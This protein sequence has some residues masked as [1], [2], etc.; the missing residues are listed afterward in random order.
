MRKLV[1]AFILLLALLPNAFSQDDEIYHSTYIILESEVRSS[2]EIEREPG[3]SIEY[4]NSEVYF[5]P[6]DDK[7]QNVLEIRPE[8]DATPYQDKFVF[9]WGSPGEN[10]LQYKI[11]S[12]VQVENLFERVF[13]KIDFPIKGG[14][15][16]DVAEFTN[17][18]EKIDSG[19]RDIISLANQL[20]EGEDD[21]FIVIHKLANWVKDNI[22][23]NLDTVTE[24]ATQKA[25][26]VLENRYGVCDE[27]TALFMAMARSLGI[28]ARFVSGIS[29]TNDP[30]FKEKWGP[31]GWAEVYL[32]GYGWVPFDVTY[33]E[34]GW[35]D[36][37]HIK[38]SDD[39]DPD[40]PSGKIEWKG[41]NFDVNAGRFEFSVDIVETG[42]RILDTVGITARVHKKKTGFGSYNLVEANIKN[43]RDY[44]VTT[45]I[46][47]GSPKEVEVIGKQNRQIILKPGESKKEFW[48]L[49]VSPSLSRNYVYT[50]PVVAYNQRNT[51]YST[52][53]TAQHDETVY[54][55]NEI[56]TLLGLLEEE[57]EKAYSKELDIECE[58]EKPEFYVYEQNKLSCMLENRGN[59]ALNGLNVC[60]GGSCKEVDITIA[61]RE[62]AIFDIK[63]AEPG[64]RDLIVT[65]K[66][67]DVSKTAYVPAVILDEPSAAIENIEFPAEARYDE[68]GSI[69]F[70]LI[71]ESYSDLYSAKV[72]VISKRIRHK[73]D[74]DAIN[75]T[76]NFILD[77]VA[78]DLAEG[79]NEITVLV[80][81]ED[82][83]G[84]QYSAEEKFKIK[85]TGLNLMQSL[86][87]RVKGAGF[88]FINLFS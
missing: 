40:R 12:T 56:S 14:V 23:Y 29:F 78:K 75:T 37:S 8:P 46:S 5:F 80:E 35:I 79:D 66:N 42:G 77:F 70:T 57:E 36:P 6:K 51:T 48:I 60:F 25:S 7:R 9:N 22:E 34:L 33:G 55:E 76:R 20:A 44:Y 84:K 21:L 4:I 81:F 32:P 85:L 28:P 71:K 2:L 64:E 41:R 83:N 15:P 13:N 11:S 58:A 3:A 52:E 73:W 87:V 38:L 61:Q 18:T 74:I 10:L 69:K 30:Q 39:I 53:F 68:T 43:R 45:D 16:P 54:S 67:A 47:L 50:F 27:L 26:W 19:N 65:A 17:P 24:E 88:W 31:H 62:R 49:R 72:Q 59:T 82:R 63:D 1:I 86:I